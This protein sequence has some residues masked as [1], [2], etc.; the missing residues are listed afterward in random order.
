MENNQLVPRRGDLTASSKISLTES[1]QTLAVEINLTSL[2]SKA[3]PEG[4]LVA[5]F[6]REF[7]SERPENIQWAFREHRRT[8]N[9]FPTISEIRTLID[10]R[11][12]ELWE[13]YEI[14]R[15]REEKAEE[16]KARAE[17]RLIGNGEVIEMIKKTV[18]RF[19]EPPHIVRHHRAQE[20]AERFSTPALQLTTEEIAARREEERA[21][22]ARYKALSGG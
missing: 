8:S 1:Q 2:N 12:R 5:E 14:E 22:L 20:A 9:F 13:A 7:T 19:P 15:Q 3:I 17:G 6:S 4:E 21:E 16:D 11:R 10:R 18:K